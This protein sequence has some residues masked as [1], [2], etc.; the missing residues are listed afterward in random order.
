MVNI[1]HQYPMT[2]MTTLWR[3]LIIFTLDG[4]L[5]SMAGTLVRESGIPPEQQGMQHR[6]LTTKMWVPIAQAEEIIFPTY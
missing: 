5:R 6:K 1:A 2:P 4:T 3:C